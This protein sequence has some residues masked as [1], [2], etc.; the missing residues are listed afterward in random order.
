MH[1]QGLTKR[2]CLVV[3]AR[4]TARGMHRHRHYK[5]LAQLFARNP[6]YLLG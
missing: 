1:Q 2:F 5:R 3:P 4:S 6:K